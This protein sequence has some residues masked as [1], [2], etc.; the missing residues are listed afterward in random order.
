MY[1]PQVIDTN[2][3]APREHIGQKITLTEMVKTLPPA[4]RGDALKKFEAFTVNYPHLAELRQRFPEYQNA[5]KTWNTADK[6]FEEKGRLPSDNTLWYLIGLSR[7]RFKNSQTP[8]QNNH[9]YGFYPIPIDMTELQ[10]FIATHESQDADLD[11]V[12]PN[13][14]KESNPSEVKP[15]GLTALFSKKT[16]RDEVT[17]NAIYGNSV[18]VYPSNIEHV[19]I[20][21]T[22]KRNCGLIFVEEPAGES[23]LKESKTWPS[24]GKEWVESDIAVAITTEGGLPTANESRER[25]PEIEGAEANMFDKNTILIPDIMLLRKQ[26]IEY[27]LRERGKLETN[28]LIPVGK[29][30][31]SKE[32][33]EQWLNRI[34]FYMPNIIKTSGSEKA[35]AEVEE[36]IWRKMLQPT[37]KANLELMKVV[38]SLI[39][40]SPDRKNAYHQKITHDIAMETYCRDTFLGFHTV[41]KLLDNLQKKDQPTLTFQDAQYLSYGLSLLAMLYQHKQASVSK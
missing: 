17:L 28:P 19:W 3:Q 40:K 11:F 33:L 12:V 21:D 4:F 16:K 13:L 2:R 24:S 1:E 39:G 41:A 22:G 18:K 38:A 14:D 20:V 15:K 6:L 10:Q 35:V 31:I 9:Q 37:R 36:Q 29:M 34:R 8:N 32:K 30:P 26:I 5:E 27:V 23:L 7:I 25:I